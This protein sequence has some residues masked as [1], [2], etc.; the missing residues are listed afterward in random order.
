[1]AIVEM[2]STLATVLVTQLAMRVQCG[3]AGPRVL[4][5][6][7]DGFPK[8]QL[9][10]HTWDHLTW[11][12]AHGSH[13][14]RFINQFPTKSFPNHFSVATGL[15]EESHGVV[16]NKVFDPSLN[17]TLT[18]KDPELFTQNPGVMPLWTL[19]ELHGGHSGCIMWPG[20]AVPFHGRNVTFSEP[21]RDNATFDEEV[22]L[23][24]KW[25]T[26][27]MKPANLIFFYHD[28]PDMAGHVYGPNSSYYD[29]ELKKIDAGLGYLFHMLDLRGLK[30]EVDVV[31]LSDH[32]MAQISSITGIIDLDTILDPGLYTFTGSSP[33]LNIWPIKEK[34][35]YVYAK[36]QDGSK[37]Y[38]YKV[39]MKEDSQMKAWHYMN[40][41]R[42]SSIT[43]VANDGYV[44]QD[45]KGFIKG[46][47]DKGYPG[48][49]EMFGDHGYEVDN[50]SMEPIFVAVGPSFR[51]KFTAE[52]FSN[53]DVYPLLCLMLG[54]PPGPNNG[55][56]DNI[57]PIL[58]QPIT[59]RLIQPLLVALAWQT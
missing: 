59:T 17:R 39:Y 51:Q 47:K 50:P 49:T 58:A 26:H 4:V 19:N 22:D 46:H 48:L 10:R 3:G 28:Q 33:V 18:I 34:V 20:C 44:F 53:L 1:M 21:Y 37:A 2:W 42:I 56:L 29:E 15:F 6:A 16:G 13:P 43:L 8:E 55:S 11:V 25:L 35:V 32:G 54:L 7:L 9:A 5:V 24:V 40:N 45:V 12:Y 38:P 31:I 57:Y 27:P 14:R 30:K 41:P 36:L 23:A 52:E